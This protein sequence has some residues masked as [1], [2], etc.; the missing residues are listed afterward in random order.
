MTE[1]T[2]K[3]PRGRIVVGVDG[4]EAS[5]D[6]LLWAARQAELT[7]ASL[8]AVLTWQ[9]PL[10]AYGYAVPAPVGAG[11][12]PQAQRRLGV[13]EDPRFAAGTRAVAEAVAS[14]RA[15]TVVG[16]GDSASAL[17]VFGLDDQVDH[18]S[19]GGG[20]SLE[21]IEKGDLPGLAA[22]R[23]ATNYRQL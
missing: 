10:M 18:L 16:G 3:G 4:S 6:A 1:T 8:E 15:F 11:P 23:S 20:A 12:E 2:K 22:L 13:F 19:T 7:G 14:A 5:K 21:F 17:R 9:L